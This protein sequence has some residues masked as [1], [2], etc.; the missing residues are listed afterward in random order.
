[1]EV[2]AICKLSKR[3]RQLNL[4]SQFAVDE[5]TW[6]PYQLKFYIPLL[7]MHYKDQRNLKQANAVAEL[8]SA[9][10][11]D[12]FPSMAN[13]Q[14]LLTN[15]NNEGGD[16]ESLKEVLDNS[17]ITKEI[18]DIL[19]VL[20]N[21]DSSSFILI[22]GPPGIG[23][24]VLL[25][26][27]SYRWANK[28]LLQE[29][30]LVLL[31]CLRDPMVQQAK[32]VDDLLHLYC[33]GD[34]RASEIVSPSC[35]QLLDNGGK[36]L[37]F[38]LD[39]FDEL[40]E[41]LQNSSLIADIIKRHVLPQCGLVLSSR[42]HASKKFHNK[43]TLIV[44]ILGFTE[45]GRRQCMEQAFHDKPQKLKELLQ[46]LN[47]HLQINSLC[48][49]PFNMIVLLFL[50]EQRNSLPKNS[51]EM[52][53]HFICL[54]ICRYL[55]R[56]GHHLNNT[57]T[58]LSNIPKP[59]NEIIEQLSRLSLQALGDNKLIFTLA[60]IKT[61][62]PSIEV[63]P[64]A[65]NA[66]GLL[67]A[68]Q[69]IG[70]T[71]KTLT[72][73]FIH[74]SIQ[75]Y[76]AAYCITKLSPPEELQILK[77]NFWLINYLNTFSIYI[78]LT[79]GQ[80][81]S[82]KTFLSDGNKRVNISQQ[83]LNQ[84]NA[85][86]HL[87]YCFYEAGDEKMCE[88][89]AKAQIFDN[90]IIKAHVSLPTIVERLML[91]LTTSSQQTWTKLML[92]FIQDYG[93]H[94]LHRGLKSSCITIAQLWLIRCGLTSSS[95]KFLSD[96]VISC[97]VKRLML[98][99]NKTVGENEQLYSMLS[100]QSTE[101]EILSMYQT[102]LS[103]RAANILF[104]IL[105]QNNTLKILSIEGNN[106][107][108]DACPFIANAIKQNSCLTKLWI[109][110]NPISAEA[111]EL[112]LQALLFNRTLEILR[113][114]AYPDDVVRRINLIQNTINIARQECGYQAKLLIDFS[115]AIDPLYCDFS[116]YNI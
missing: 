61:V 83:F 107:S 18:A 44:E 67:K 93:L 78:A 104:T 113:L 10:R 5:E 46:Y 11:I 27:I 47:N 3:V 109:R 103:S 80:Q 102:S 34:K 15:H 24:S 58:D 55:A 66:F 62:C 79:K 30:K 70:L 21:K 68:V 2:D 82:F 86:F 52:Y 112:I 75:E 71:G 42:P 57:I 85:C 12:D 115:T 110:F 84:V 48:F 33:K 39:G 88:S 1:M 35:D 69:Y 23:K 4:A 97:R 56:S 72:F 8:V 106:I 13:D 114:P 116:S 6:P 26:E 51:S 45:E 96:I 17:K 90:K 9:G 38:L 99:Y 54:I 81:P 29:Y 7:L 87:Y 64:G 98:D 65:I 108:D 92:G 111:I 60:E 101:L 76:L 91:F 40:P 95:A 41:C 16:H 43:A 32:S 73:N 49:V 20:E 74:F 77:D 25:K 53:K 19:A 89:I 14:A 100:H 63:I 50:F 31:L 22:E 59:Y 37:T 105:E 28:Q 94:V 36:D